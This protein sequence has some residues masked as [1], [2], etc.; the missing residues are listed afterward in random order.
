[1]SPSEELLA[2]CFASGEIVLLD[3]YLEVKARHKLDYQVTSS[4]LDWRFDS[5]CFCI[6]FSSPSGTRAFTLGSDL[7]PVLST[8][9]EHPDHP[10]VSNVFEKPKPDLAAH[11]RWAA[12]GS[13]AYGIRRCKSADTGI[14]AWV[15]EIACK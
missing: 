8:S 15:R 11:V 3:K 1:M 9:L 6:A 12:N 10:L 13:L 2:L 14:V 5:E 7:V 4:F